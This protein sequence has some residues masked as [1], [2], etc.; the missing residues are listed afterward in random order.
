MLPSHDKLILSSGKEPTT[1]GHGGAG[2]E[3]QVAG[4]I[5]GQ[6]E[7]QRGRQRTDADASIHRS[8]FD[9]I[10]I[11]GVEQNLIRRPHTG[12]RREGRREGLRGGPVPPSLPPCPRIPAGPS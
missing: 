8:L 10:V 4:G 11:D 7:G 12:L 1:K 9:S 5:G 3:C 6:E 2:E